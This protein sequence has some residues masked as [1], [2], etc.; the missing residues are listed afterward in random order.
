MTELR[1]DRG[2][3]RRV[4][5]VVLPGLLFAVSLLAYLATVWLGSVSAIPIDGQGGSAAGYSVVLTAFLAYSAIGAIVAARRPE[6]HVGWLL[7][8]MGVIAEIQ[9]LASGTVEYAAGRNGSALPG[10]LL[11]PWLMAPLVNLWVVSFSALG[12]LLFIFPNGRLFS[13]SIAPG[14]TLAG[15]TIAVGLVTSN[16]TTTT[17]F[18]LFDALFSTNVADGLYGLGRGVS[19]LSLMALLVLGTIS[20]VVRL[21][22]ARGVERQQMKWFAYA[23]VA[24]ALVFVGTAAAF[25]SPLRA[26]DPGARF[27][28][29]MFGGVPFLLALMALPIGA[30]VA[31]LRYRLYDIDVLINRTLVYGALSATLAAT[32]FAGVVL[33][34]A[35][36]RPLIG[37]SE[38]PV[39]LSTL[40]V[41]ALFA[42]LRRRI[43]R[44]VDRR[45]YRSRYDAAHTLDA[46]GARL[47]DEVDLEAV[48]GDLLA[49]VHQTVRPAH[50]SV[51]LR[52]ARR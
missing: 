15:F 46:F 41:V 12:L 26:L 42:P 18:P 34:Q 49:A 37:G 50:A 28:A 35:A 40:A 3:T 31:I 33:L 24:L 48:R 1:R 20:M 45:F 21:R 11:D 2:A 14:L 16:G 30:A 19:G 13:R 6:Y 8:V 52:E 7:C 29:A 10:W 25:F 23:A 44:V 43:Q 4:S 22:R 32:Y 9:G 27:P 51:W 39:A 17:R 38:L 5:P 36:L 47:R